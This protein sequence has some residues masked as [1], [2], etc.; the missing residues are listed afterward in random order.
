MTPNEA[1]EFLCMMDCF[2]YVLLPLLGTDEW[3]AWRHPGEDPV[4]AV[5]AGRVP[6]DRLRYVLAGH[7]HAAQVWGHLGGWAAINAA[8]M[9]THRAQHAAAALATRLAA[10]PVFRT[11]CLAVLWGLRNV[12]PYWSPDERLSTLVHVVV[13]HWGARKTRM[14][15]DAWNRQQPHLSPF[16]LPEAPRPPA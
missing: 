11:G 9:H 15:I 8:A 10:T 4:G 1:S 16:L 2:F 5:H 13:R 7:P 3:G 12:P 6:H 14:V